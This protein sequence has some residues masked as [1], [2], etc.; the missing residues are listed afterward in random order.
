MIELSY[1]IASPGPIKSV[2]RLPANSI[3]TPILLTPVND[4]LY[5]Q[6]ACLTLAE[7]QT[8]KYLRAFFV[9]DCF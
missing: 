1:V 9:C 6:T 2:D 3:N 4:Q 5:A 8:D 7:R